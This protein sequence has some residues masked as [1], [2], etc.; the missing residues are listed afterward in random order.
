MTEPSRLL[1]KRISKILLIS[2]PGKITYT[3]E[4]SR[5]RKLAVPPLGLAS[6]AARLRQEGLDVQI[7]DVMMEGYSNEQINGRQILYGLGDADVRK[8]IASF[9]PDL[10]GVS[11]LFSNRGR[12]ALHLCRLAKEAAPDAHV[13]LGGQHPSGMPQLVLDP[14]VDYLMY[15]EADNS[16]V[17]LIQAIDAGGDLREV[18]Q[19][20]LKDGD[21]FWKSPKNDYPDPR[22]LPLPAWELVDLEQYWSA[23][24][25][26]YEINTKGYKRFL[27]TMTS[28]GCPH[29]C[30]FCTAP[31]MSDKRFRRKEI[32][33]VIAEIRHYRDAYGI[34]EMHFWDDN[35]F[36]SVKRMKALLRAL[37]KNFPDMTFQVPSGSEVNAID[38]EAIDLLADAHFTKLFLAIES[39]NPELQHDVID[40][41]VKLERIPAIVAKLRSRG[42]IS[43]GSFMVGFPHESRAQ[44]DH[45]FEMASK[46]GLDRISISIVNPLPGTPLY[47]ECV[48]DGLLHDDFDPQN[49]RWS[50]ENIRM[51]GV[52]R[53]YLQKR[54]REVWESYMKDRID[55]TKYE[56]QNIVTD[57]DKD[58]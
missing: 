7:L 47:D 41:H 57:Y 14:N 37:A 32:D 42:I 38:D 30:Y 36:I 13:V 49:I 44:I 53:G 46:L 55:I 31:L 16:F 2:P 39:L 10:I 29:E 4:G 17:Q 28:R 9:D 56:T 11:C 48:R 52:E 12:E 5:E 6:L 35:F 1:R 40:K 19:I 50:Q 3:E 43:E 27:I 24:L 15:G 58:K 45:T 25:A 23:G 54:R 51:D 34:N 22:R 26:D 21:K 18:S 33:E 20:V 8:R